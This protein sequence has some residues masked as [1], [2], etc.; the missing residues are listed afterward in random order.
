MHMKTSEM[1]QW[2]SHILQ[3][4]HRNARTGY[5]GIHLCVWESCCHMLSKLIYNLGI[6]GLYIG[7]VC[8]W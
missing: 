2:S 5:K 6:G 4:G 3:T 1:L 8:I 7:K